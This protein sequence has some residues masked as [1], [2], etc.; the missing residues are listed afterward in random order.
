VRQDEVESRD[1]NSKLCF[2]D[3]YVYTLIYIQELVLNT[4]MKNQQLKS[5]ELDENK[6]EERNKAFAYSG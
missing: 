2:S 4:F 3:W 1:K 6:E 5:E